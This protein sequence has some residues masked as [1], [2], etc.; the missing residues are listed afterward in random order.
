[1][2]TSSSVD[3]AGRSSPED[4][5]RQASIVRTIPR[6][7]LHLVVSAATGA[8]EL[9]A[10]ADRYRELSPDWLV[11]TKIDES[12]G[13]GGILSASVRISGR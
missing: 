13:P 12:A 9:A 10:V 3:T 4:V 6:V 2:P 11:L 5:Q 7:Q 1:M 8:Q